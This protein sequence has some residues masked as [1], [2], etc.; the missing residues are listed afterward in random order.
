MRDLSDSLTVAHL[1]RATWAICSQSIVC[2]EQ[3]EQIAH[4]CSFD[5]SDGRMSEFPALSIGQWTVF[6]DIGPGWFI[7]DRW[8]VLLKMA[9]GNVLNSDNT[10]HFKDLILMWRFFYVCV[11]S[12]LEALF[13]D[14]QFIYLK[15]ILLSSGIW[16]SDPQCFSKF[17]L[18]LDLARLYWSQL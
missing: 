14:L 15:L 11:F 8:F 4:S 9:T 17:M 7:I 6:I 10:L 3:S 18:T 5:L 2:L 12:Y 13:E 16:D 1:S